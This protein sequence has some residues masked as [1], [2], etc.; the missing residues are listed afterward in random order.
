MEYTR[1]RL[2]HRP[3]VTCGEVWVEG[4]SD[5]SFSSTPAKASTL[6]Q[7]SLQSREPCPLSEPNADW[8]GHELSIAH[9]MS[10]KGHGDNVTDSGRGRSVGIRA[11]CSIEPDGRVRVPYEPLEGTRHE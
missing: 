10:C 9:V 7:E 8:K 2:C 1:H 3:G 4:L 5:S 6:V 11:T